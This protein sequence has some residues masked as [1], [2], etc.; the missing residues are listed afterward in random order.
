MARDL[1]GLRHFGPGYW[2]Q[3]CFAMIGMA[4]GVF[5]GGYLYDIAGSY[6]VAWLISFGSGLLSSLLA[7]DLILQGERAQAA[8]AA[9]ATESVRAVHS[10]S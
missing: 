2:G 6:A 7:M 3:M 4:V 5:L 1:Y 10:A 8:Q 9:T